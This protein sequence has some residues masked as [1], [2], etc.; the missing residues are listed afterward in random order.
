MPTPDAPRRDTDRVKDR[1]TKITFD[2]EKVAMRTAA[3]RRRAE[4]AAAMPDA[5][6]ALVAHADAVLA[7]AGGGIMAGYLPIR[8]ELS[9]LP[10]MRALVGAGCATAMPITPPPGN[11]LVDGPYNTRQPPDDGNPVTP[12]LILAPMLAFDDA[13]RRLGYGGGFYDRTL[14]KIRDGGHAVTAIGIAYDEQRTDRVPTGPHDMK[15][16][17]VLTP[18]GLRLVEGG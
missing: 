13:A 7:L 15:L 3:S 16:D 11:P 1:V 18:A 14:A 17:G 4:L 8:S 12:G 9:P 10:L 6:Q 2:D 5:N